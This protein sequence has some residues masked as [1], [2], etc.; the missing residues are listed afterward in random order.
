MRLG[1]IFILAFISGLGC[2]AREDQSRTDAQPLEPT[3]SI[4]LSADEAANRDAAVLQVVFDDL[5]STDN[6]E[7]PFKS[8]SVSSEPV[9]VSR[10]APRWPPRTGDILHPIDKKK[11]DAL[12]AAQLEAA[13]QA[14]DDLVQRFGMQAS[15]PEFRSASGRLKVYEDAGATTQRTRENPF[16][17]RGSDVYVPGYSKDGRYAVVRLGFPWSI[18]SGDATYIVERTEH[19]WKVLLRDF[20][21]YL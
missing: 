7:S 13:T 10:H 21:Y 8:H 19:G 9:Y 4:S 12:T 2:T 18:H 16:P 20:V 14:A 17:D 6:E 5:L 3:L 15:L 1:V 11:W